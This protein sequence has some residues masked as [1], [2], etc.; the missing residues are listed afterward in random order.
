MESQLRDATWKLQQLQVQ[1]DYLVSKQSSQ[2]EAGKHTELQLEDAQHKLR[3]L[4]RVC[5][6]L[7]HEKEMNDMKVARIP[8]LEDQI[9]ELKQANAS[10]EEKITR[11]CEAPFI[12]DAFGQHE[13]RIQYQDLIKEKEQLV[14][15]V[16]HLQEAVRT[17]FSA[18]N[19]LKQQAAQLRGEK[20]EAHKK[21][22][23][24][25]LQLKD[26]EKGTTT[27]QDQL[28]MYTGDDG[29]DL[30]SLEKALTMVKRRDLALEHLSFLEN[31]DGENLSDADYMVT[32][33]MMKKKIQ[34]HQLTN[35]RMIQENERLEH[36]LKI[37][38][39]I[40]Q[41]LNKEIQS[42]VL[43]KTKDTVE[44]KDKVSSLESLA[45]SRLDKIHSLEAQLKQFIYGLSKQVKKKGTSGMDKFVPGDI[46]AFDGMSEQKEGYDPST[47][48]DPE[49]QVVLLDLLKDPDGNIQP[50]ENVLEIWVKE[51]KINQGVLTAGSSTFVVIDFFDY[52][53]QTTSILNGTSPQWDFAATYKL[54]IDD[55]L[56]RYLA[57]DYITLELNMVRGLMYF[58]WLPVE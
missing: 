57:T 21:I 2:T 58:L 43:S 16:E 23:E 8:S 11:L 31:P 50:Y 39:H 20:D 24:L 55:F 48:I 47:M 29:I 22:E 42:L 46:L 26:M 7:R 18:L 52:E 34:E 27:L 19:T 38:T 25:T 44:Y 36:M 33:P 5:E 6:E 32:I 4:R 37:Q 30:E 3:E 15:Q 1:Y 14:F 53:S 10:L 17:H 54:H 9:S 41:D 40:N 45:M 12:N 56:L 28:R 35:L 49:H 13:M 51:A